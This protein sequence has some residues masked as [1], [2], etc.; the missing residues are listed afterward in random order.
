MQGAT[1]RFYRSDVALCSYRILLAALSWGGPRFRYAAQPFRA[2]L[3]AHGFMELPR[4]HGLFSPE[5]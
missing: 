2:V 4:L 5:Q 1:K 3:A